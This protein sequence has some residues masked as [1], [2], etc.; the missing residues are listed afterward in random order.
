MKKLADISAFESLQNQTC[1]FTVA[2]TTVFNGICTDE[3]MSHVREYKG[4]GG[5]PSWPDRDC[6]DELIY[7]FPYEIAGWVYTAL[8]DKIN[9]NDYTFADLYKLIFSE[10]DDITEACENDLVDSGYRKKESWMLDE[11]TSLL[12]TAVLRE[13]AKNDDV[14]AKRDESYSIVS[15]AEKADKS[16]SVQGSF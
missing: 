11:P 10:C 14:R 6:F 4:F 5:G 2:D 8:K 7:D 13:I 15:G 16:F 12:T 1:S 9:F 3:V